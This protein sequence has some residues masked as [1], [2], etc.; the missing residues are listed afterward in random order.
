M[1]YADTSAA[2]MFERRRG[3]TLTP[4]VDGRIQIHKMNR[5]ENIEAV[6]SELQARGLTQNFDDKS[7]WT[8]LLTLLKTD[9][10]DKNYFRLRITY[11]SFEWLPYHY[12]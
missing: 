1:K 8:N 3:Q 2:N 10:G 6:R 4:L 12:T 11:D 9:E 5:D 7:T